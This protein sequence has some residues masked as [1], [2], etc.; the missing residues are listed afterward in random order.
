MFPEQENTVLEKLLRN[1]EPK[2][3]KFTESINYFLLLPSYSYII[4]VLSIP[5]ETAKST[6]EST[7]PWEAEIRGDGIGQWIINSLYKHLRVN[8]ILKF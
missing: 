5:K 6:T 7:S 2:K 4:N 8:C 1:S 3:K